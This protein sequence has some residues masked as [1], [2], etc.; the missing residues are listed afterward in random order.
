M[1]V[2]VPLAIIAIVFVDL[3]GIPWAVLMIVAS[4]LCMS[5]LY[6]M[7]ARWR[8]IQMVGFAGRGGDGD[9]RALRQRP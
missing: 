3:G 6:E 9:R 5:E 1:L 7:L 2:G 8:P 4:V